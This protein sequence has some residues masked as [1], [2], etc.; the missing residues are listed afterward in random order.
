MVN[1]AVSPER[2]DVR[3]TRVRAARLIAM[4][5]DVLQIA[6]FPMFVG[7][8]ASPIDDVL[9]VVVAGA[10]TWL[11][12]WHWSFLPSFVAELVPGLDLV[13]TWTA[14]VFFAT[15]ARGPLPP[16]SGAP[17][18][19]PAPPAGTIDAEVISSEPAPPGTTARR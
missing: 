19:R 1:P 3:A 17:T 5:A 7:G 9:D 8:A 18:F 15:R 4:A 13:P 14:A 16:P 11:V 6:V 2:T 12:G 10:V